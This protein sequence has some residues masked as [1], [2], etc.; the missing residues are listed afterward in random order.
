MYGYAASALRFSLVHTVSCV[1]TRSKSG[2][3]L[4]RSGFSRGLSGQYG[5][6]SGLPVVRASMPKWYGVGQSESNPKSNRLMAQIGCLA[7]DL[8]PNMRAMSTV[9]LQ[10]MEEAVDFLHPIDATAVMRGSSDLPCSTRSVC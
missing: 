4:S 9:R 10:S 3:H 8:A 1:A 2:V 6:A 5:V 7:S